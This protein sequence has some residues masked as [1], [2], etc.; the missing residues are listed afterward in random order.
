LHSLVSL[1]GVVSFLA[2][3]SGDPT[4][5]YLPVDAS[6]EARPVIEIPAI[7]SFQFAIA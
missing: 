4:N 6:L 3:L 1:L 2:R 7:L 5:L